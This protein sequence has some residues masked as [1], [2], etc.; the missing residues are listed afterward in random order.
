MAPTWFPVSFQINSTSSFLITLFYTT[1]LSHFIL[2]N[3]IVPKN[4]WWRVGS[5]Y[6]VIFFFVLLP[7]L[8]W[9][10]IFSEHLVFE[11]S[12]YGLFS[13]WW[14]TKF[15]TQ[16]KQ[17]VFCTEFN[18]NPRKRSGAETQWVMN[19]VCFHCSKCTGVLLSTT[20]LDILSQQSQG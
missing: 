10:Q 6:Y 1:C 2:H 5:L 20:D 11:M 9:V 3:L 7:S 19:M 18:H 12:V 14:D 13:L 16:I 17:Q 15:H 4:V 8:S